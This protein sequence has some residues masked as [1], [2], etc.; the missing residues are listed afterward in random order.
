[1]NEKDE[2]RG[3]NVQ[4]T[5]ENERLKISRRT[6]YTKQ[7]SKVWV[8]LEQGKGQVKKEKFFREEKTAA[9]GRMGQKK[10][11]LKDNGASPKKEWKGRQC[12]TSIA[13]ALSYYKQTQD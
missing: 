8:F 6:G 3:R 1:M 4:K 10:G 5:K 13:V 2:R 12:Q 11:N 9:Q 7:Q